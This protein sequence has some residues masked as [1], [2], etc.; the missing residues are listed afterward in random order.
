MTKLIDLKEKFQHLSKAPI[1]EAAL[2]VRVILSMKWDEISLQN[3][4]KQRLPDYPS[5]E[6]RQEKKIQLQ[7]PSTEK[8]FNA[9]VEDNG[10]VGFT[11]QSNDKL[12]I[13]R[14]NKDAYLFSHLKPYENWGCFSKEAL[15][16]WGIYCDLLKP[17]EIE[18]I[19]LRFVNQILIEQDTIE[20]ANYY[21]YPPKSLKG[22]DW[23]LVDYFHHDVIRVPETPYVVNLIKTSKKNSD[24]TSLIL[25]IDVFRQEKIVYYNELRINECL[26]EM[27]WVKN[28]VFYSSVISKM[29]KEF[30]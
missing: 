16:L 27:R 4:L 29:L 6:P 18:R 7:L 26:E 10:C 28:K 5:I 14:F 24:K 3:E 21:K 2:E 23:P 30:K 1:V 22:L 12:N 25:D 20:F 9:T 15:R 17:A 13:V 19:G 11:C 8:Q